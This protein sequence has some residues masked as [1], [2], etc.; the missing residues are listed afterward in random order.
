M[1]FKDFGFHFT[2]PNGNAERYAQYYYKKN[3]KDFKKNVI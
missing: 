3:A 2:R 1:I